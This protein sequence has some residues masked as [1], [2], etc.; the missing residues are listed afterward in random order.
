[1][2]EG[3]LFSIVIWEAAVHAQK[4]TQWPLLGR[5]HNNTMKQKKHL[6]ENPVGGL[7]K[8]LSRKSSPS[9]PGCP[10]P[11]SGMHWLQSYRRHIYHSGA[12]QSQISAAPL[13][14]VIHVVM[15]GYGALLPTI[16][17]CNL[18]ESFFLLP[19]INS[20]CSGLES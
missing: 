5:S 20:S 14:K 7:K 8:N 16:E 9:A 18:E 6:I 19:I 13:L 11:H 4:Q 10:C 3:C 12:E 17:I 2:T 15:Y 1:M